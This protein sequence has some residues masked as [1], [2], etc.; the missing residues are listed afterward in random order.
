MS[1]TY[2][3]QHGVGRGSPMATFDV[4]ARGA[5]GVLV[6]A[7]EIDMASADEFRDEMARC[8][9]RFDVVEV[10]LNDVS[11][12][13]SSGLSSLVWAHRAA[14]AEGQGFA[15]VNLSPITARLL[16]VSGLRDVFNVRPSST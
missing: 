3:G 9:Q 1:V 4:R 8:L 11:F 14:A 12:I 2:Q 15:L 6:V 13:D 7:G 5:D 10:D 16:E